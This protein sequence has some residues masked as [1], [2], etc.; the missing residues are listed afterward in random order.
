MSDHKRR[1]NHNALQEN[2]HYQNS[3]VKC[4]SF[5]FQ[6]PFLDCEDYKLLNK[7]VIHWRLPC[8]YVTA[9]QDRKMIAISSRVAL[10][11]MEALLQEQRLQKYE[12]SRSAK[13]VY[14]TAC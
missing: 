11:K 10:H 2:N 5:C 8:S 1:H 6:M 9:W 12:G 3:N 4:T 7:Q 13:A 14:S